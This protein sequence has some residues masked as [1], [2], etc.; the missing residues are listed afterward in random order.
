MNKH[1]DPRLVSCLDYGVLY[2]DMFVGRK[3]GGMEVTDLAV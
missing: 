3:E 1:M 2:I